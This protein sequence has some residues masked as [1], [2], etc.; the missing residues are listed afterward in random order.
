[1]RVDAELSESFHGEVGVR[2][3]CAMSLRLL[4]ILMGGCMREIRVQLRSVVACYL[5]DN[6][7]MLAE[8]TKG[9]YE[10]SG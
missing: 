2:Y 1:M 7:V 10:S 9:S 6:T 8:S 3:G 4:D 5:A